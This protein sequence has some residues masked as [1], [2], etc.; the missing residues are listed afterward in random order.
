MSLNVSPGVPHAETLMF[1][2]IGEGLEAVL[3][4]S[5]V[6]KVPA[7]VLL[8][9]SGILM[10]FL[11]SV[12]ESIWSTNGQ[13]LEVL[14]LFSAQ[15]SRVAFLV[16]SDVNLLVCGGLEPCFFLFSLEQSEAFLIL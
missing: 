15:A 4:C 2:S 1:G 12:V 6:E 14:V 9:F 8:I 11:S 16:C 5:A 3:I 13:I 7:L 10:T